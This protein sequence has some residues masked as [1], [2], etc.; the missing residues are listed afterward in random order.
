MN[1]APQN[2][3]TDLIRKMV[4]LQ[5]KLLVDGIRDAALIPISLIAT[6]LGL[7]RGGPDI[8]R[9]LNTVLD[10]GR[11]SERWINLFGNHPPAGS[12][13]SLLN[14]VETVITEQYRKGRTEEE[15]RAAVKEAMDDEVGKPAP[16]LKDN[17]PSV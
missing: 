10:F 3:R 13:D 14:R 1:D 8:D 4:V 7:I 16:D 12:L 15:A 2:A 17:Q 6:L 9:E 11:Q 5:L